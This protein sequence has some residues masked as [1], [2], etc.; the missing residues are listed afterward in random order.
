MLNPLYIRTVSSPS[1]KLERSFWLSNLAKTRVGYMQS[2]TE[3]VN[4]VSSVTN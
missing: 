2:Q 3:S 4:L 1:L